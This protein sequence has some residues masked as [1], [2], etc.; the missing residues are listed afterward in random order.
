MKTAKLFGVNYFDASKETHADIEIQNSV[1]EFNN[2][3]V[4]YISKNKSVLK[5]QIQSKLK[6]ALKLLDG[7]YRVALNRVPDIE[8][9][10]NILTALIKEK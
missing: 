2:G 4:V 3:D 1:D 10:L 5:S 6:E 9:A 7:E 8:K